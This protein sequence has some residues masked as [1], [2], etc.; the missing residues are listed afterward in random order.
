MPQATQ[1]VA[2]QASAVRHAVLVRQRMRPC[3]YTCKHAQTL[4]ERLVLAVG[5]YSLDGIVG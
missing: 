2:L 3:K 1:A 4:I 5:G